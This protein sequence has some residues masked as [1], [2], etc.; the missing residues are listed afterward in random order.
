MFIKCVRPDFYEI[1]ICG[2]GD[3]SLNCAS[4][5]IP[6]VLRDIPDLWTPRRAFGHCRIAWFV[7]GYFC[8]VDKIAVRRPSVG[9]GNGHRYRAASGITLIN[10]DV[11]ELTLAAG[12]VIPGG[13]AINKIYK[14]SDVSGSTCKLRERRNGQDGNPVDIQSSGSGT[15]HIQKAA[16]YALWIRAHICKCEDLQGSSPVHYRLYATGGSAITTDWSEDFKISFIDRYLSLYEALGGIKLSGDTTLIEDGDGT[17]KIVLPF[18]E[19][20]ISYVAVG[21]CAHIAGSNQFNPGHSYTVTA[22]DS[23]TVTIDTGTDGSLSDTFIQPKHI[24]YKGSDTGYG[25]GDWNEEDAKS[26]H[27]KPQTRDEAAPN[28]LTGLVYAKECEVAAP[29]TYPI[30]VL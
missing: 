18:A 19:N 11:V 3:G 6:Y 12:A 24:L 9:N 14:V 30:N 7:A 5:A 22:R 13:L 25:S 4:F 1:V 8:Y 15:L 16:C 17:F 29:S 21:D 20:P 28:N 2:R 26:Y 23:S 10:G 27:F